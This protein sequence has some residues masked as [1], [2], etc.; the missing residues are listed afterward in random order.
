MMKYAAAYGGTAV[1]LLALDSIWLTLAARPVYRAQV[2][3]LLLDQ[4]NFAVAALFY[5]FYAVGL[6]VFCVMPSAGKPWLSAAALGAL[7]GLIAYGTYDITNLA[8]LKGW[9]TTVSLIDMA[10]GTVVSAVAATAGHFALRSVL[11]G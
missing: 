5:L 4:P 6:V 10:W 7:L 1:V 3:S 8:T 2:G 9:T 11:P